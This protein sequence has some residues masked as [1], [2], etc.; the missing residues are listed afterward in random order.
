MLSANL[1]AY[2]K[3]VVHNFVIDLVTINIA[4]V[5]MKGALVAQG[6]GNNTTLV[7]TAN[8]EPGVYFVNILTEEGRATA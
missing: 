2:C 6:S 1:D 4:I 5:D 8:F 7:Q 3:S